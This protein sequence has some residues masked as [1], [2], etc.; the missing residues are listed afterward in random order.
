MSASTTSQAKP[1]VPIALSAEAVDDLIYD[2]RAGDL[3]ALNED[4]ANLVSQHSCNESQ[5]VASAIDMADESEGGSGSCI[6]HFPAA[7]GNSEIL[8]TLLQKLSSADAAQR[9]AFV[10]HRNNS[11]NTPL[12]WAALNAHLE[13]V[14]ALVEAGA[15]LE[16]KNDAGH[17]AVFLAERTAWATVEG[18]EE[19]EGAEGDDAQ[20]Q[21]IEM[22]IGE[23]EDEEKPAEGAGEVSAGRQVVEWLLASDGGANLEK[24]ATQG[25][26]SGSA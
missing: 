26:A 24:G 12:H 5:I 20:V 23:N 8:K 18:D 4:I 2:A 22:T 19:A 9:V 3:E 25:E 6:L 13:C 11:G 14:K 7:N 21:E 17:D 1:S 16:V 15:D 10:N